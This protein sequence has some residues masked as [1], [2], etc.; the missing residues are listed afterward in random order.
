MTKRTVEID[1]T[2]G[3]IVESAID[4]VKT[5]L[6]NYLQENPDTDELP[7]LNNDLDYSGAIHEIVDSAVPVYT[8]E[9]ND[10]FYLY[11]NDFE[12]AFD[13]AGIGEKDDKGWPN[14]WKAAAIYCYIEQQ[15]NEWYHKEAQDIFD[16]WKEKR[17][18]QTACQH[19]EL[20]IEGTIA[21]GDWRD[22]GNNTHCPTAEGEEERLHEPVDE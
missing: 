19:C 17:T 5:E 8:G 4:D 3:E 12:E 10:L 13:D 18:V 15:V 2:L 6:T 1:D 21:E 22:R 20:D 7:C 11:G 9:I 14:G 16:D